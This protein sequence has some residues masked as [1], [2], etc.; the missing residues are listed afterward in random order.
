MMLHPTICERLVK[1]QHSHL[2]QEARNGR[3]I[4]APPG[5][6]G[7]WRRGLLTGLFSEVGELLIAAGLW[8]QGRHGPIAPPSVRPREL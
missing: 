3:R 7:R 5:P 2:L 1:I 4:P 8:L 6:Q